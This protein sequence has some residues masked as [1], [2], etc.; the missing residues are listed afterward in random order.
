MHHYR[1]E[2]VVLQH[3]FAAMQQ[4]G[5]NSNKRVKNGDLGPINEK[6]TQ[7]RWFF[8]CWH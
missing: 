8:K 1:K 5:K 6:T 3:L 2:Y 4:I 7:I